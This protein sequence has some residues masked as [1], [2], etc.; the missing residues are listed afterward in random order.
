MCMYI[1]IYTYTHN[2][3]IYMYRNHHLMCF[4]LPITH[5]HIPS[6]FSGNKMLD[7]ERQSEESLS[8]ATADKGEGCGGFPMFVGE[9]GINMGIK[10]RLTL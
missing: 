9:N 7:L 10:L 4:F 8:Q 2:H 3:Y 1:Y 5:I 6:I